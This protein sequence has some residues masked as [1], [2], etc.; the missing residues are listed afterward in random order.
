MTRVTDATEAMARSEVYAFLALAFFDPDAETLMRLKQ[1]QMTAEAALAAIASV[2]SRS[3]FAAVSQE[4]N[5][6][7][8][9]EFAAA[10]RQVFG[11]AVSGDCPP[12]EGEY[13]HPH[14][15]QKSQSLADNAGFL[16]A[17]GLEQ[18]PGFNDR[19]DHIAVELEFMHVLAAKEAYALTHDHSGEQLATVRDATRKYLSDHLGRWAPSFAARLESKAQ[20]GLY[21]ALARLLAAFI[22]E[23]TLALD[24]TPIA[25][26]P[27]T[28]QPDDEQAAC[29]GCAAASVFNPAMRGEP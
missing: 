20:D 24:V 17:F 29:D 19:L 14:I 6:L 27:F 26:P 11:L 22:A 13:G 18:A 4:I 3:A 23:E 8:K 2:E 5:C 25:A 15:F 16:Q 21:V 28:P 12:Y 9:D 1:A 10:Y 7:E